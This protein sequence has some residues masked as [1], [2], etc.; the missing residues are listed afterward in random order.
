MKEFCE[1]TLNSSTNYLLLKSHTFQSRCSGIEITSAIFYLRLTAYRGQIENDDN[2]CRT[3][4]SHILDT[5]TDS[6]T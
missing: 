6:I 1:N 4:K 5:I 3:Q 2:I